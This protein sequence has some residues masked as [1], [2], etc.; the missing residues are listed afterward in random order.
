MSLLLKALSQVG[1]SQNDAGGRAQAGTADRDRGPGAAAYETE[2]TRWSDAA[3]AR[4]AA[5]MLGQTSARR[6]GALADWFAN[7]SIVPATLGLA[8]VIALLYGVYVWWAM[9]PHGGL[10]ASSSPTPAAPPAA[11]PM[12][13]TPPRA[14]PVAAS[15]AGTSSVS[16]APATGVEDTA[17]PEPATTT[18]QPSAESAEP[19]RTPTLRKLY[20][21]RSTPPVANRAELP[22][23]SE[24]AR[25]YEAFLAGRLDEARAAYLKELAREP[26]VEAHLGLAA[27]ATRRERLADA[28]H[29][30]SEAL[31]LDPRN[32][33]AH[34]GLIASVGVVDPLAAEARLKE[35]IAVRP[36]GYLYA[37][38]GDV[39][40]GAG[41]WADAESA[42]FEA[43][44]LEPANPDHPYNLAVA[45]ERLN[46]SKVA[47]RY[48]E[49]ALGQAAGM[50]ARFDLDA[51]RARL[52]YLKSV[53]GG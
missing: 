27:I 45:L 38:L 19:R 48:Y 30:Y 1:R 31:R 8:V 34:A 16:P 3:D 5:T 44:K 15:D 32:A 25:A 47:M 53:H 40:A 50:P 13:L 18:S 6:S 29:H 51:V 14:S 12:P 41:R 2:A 23:E 7:L 39:Y 21:T 4:I 20:P 49:R 43:H 36:M 37:T 17:G 26:G 10:F 35:L 24:L 22:A 28:V 46:Q 33:A 42:Y 11:T 52:A 9:Q